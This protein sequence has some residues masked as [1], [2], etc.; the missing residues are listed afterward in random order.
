MEFKQL[1]SWNEANRRDKY[2]YQKLELDFKLSHAKY[3]DKTN[4][5]ASFRILVT[6]LCLLIVFENKRFE[7]MAPTQ[8]K[9]T[10]LRI[11]W[12]YIRWLRYA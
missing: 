10:K 9:L 8:S 2:K 4:K 11:K 1:F 12:I 7:E 5:F 3:S 6:D